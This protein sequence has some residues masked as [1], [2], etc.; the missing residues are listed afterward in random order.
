MITEGLQTTPFEIEV[1][2]VNGSIFEEVAT[3]PEQHIINIGNW[4][5]VTINQLPQNID[6]GI[7]M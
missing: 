4:P 1:G 7:I 6:G 3:S 5:V 2:A